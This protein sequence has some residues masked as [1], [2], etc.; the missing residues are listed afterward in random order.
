MFSPIVAI[1]RNRHKSGITSPE[2]WAKVRASVSTVIPESH[3]KSFQVSCLLKVRS[4][5]HNI[6]TSINA[7]L[8]G[9]NI[10]SRSVLTR[11]SVL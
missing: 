2:F 6:Y 4:R 7:G 5:L 11:I 3:L 9:L 10:V 8:K 1:T